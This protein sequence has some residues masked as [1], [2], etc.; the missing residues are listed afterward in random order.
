MKILY[1][2]TQYKK[3][4]KKYIRLAKKITKLNEVLRMFENEEPLPP[5]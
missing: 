5:S 2:S 1:P 4:L 3:D